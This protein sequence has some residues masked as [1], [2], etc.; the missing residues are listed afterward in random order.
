MYGLTTKLA[1]TLCVTALLALGVSACS[2]QKSAAPA[3]APQASVAT[4]ATTT[5]EAVK[6]PVECSAAANAANCADILHHLGKDAAAA[7]G[8]PGH[9]PSY[10]DPDTAKLPPCKNGTPACEVWERMWPQ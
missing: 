5:P 6:P 4:T 2:Q 3:P 8:T 9:E 7:F 10:T 1:L